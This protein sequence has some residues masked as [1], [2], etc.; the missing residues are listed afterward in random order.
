MGCL[1]VTAKRIGDGLQLAAN[2]VGNGISI[3]A[4]RIGC[5]SVT[6][7][8]VC[9]INS[10]DKILWSDQYLIWLNSEVGVVKY[11]S[12]LSTQDWKLEEVTIE[13]LL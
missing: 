9:T 8:L 12:L 10:Q 6:C 13:E 5:M 2:R 7:G 11:N 3:Q 1:N 4:T